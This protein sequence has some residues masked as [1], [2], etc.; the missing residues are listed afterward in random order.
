MSMPA[1]EITPET[2][3]R[4]LARLARERF[5]G[6]IELHFEHGRIYRLVKQHSI[7][8]EEMERLAAP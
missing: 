4:F 2:L 1:S 6:R 3:S 8:K 7:E 5:F